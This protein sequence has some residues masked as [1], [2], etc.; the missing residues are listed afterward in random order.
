MK[1]MDKNE[2]IKSLK[3]KDL[4]QI[5]KQVSQIMLEGNYGTTSFTTYTF[6]G[7]Y[8][9]RLHNH[10][11]GKLNEKEVLHKFNNE[12]EFWNVPEKYAEIG[13]CNDK[14]ESM[15]YCANDIVTAILEVKPKAGDFVTVSNFKNLFP[16]KEFKIQPIAVRSLSKIT[17]LNKIL[18]RNYVFNDKHLNV[19][20][21]LDKL[22]CGKDEKNY[23]LSVAISHL[24]FTDTL[25]KSKT[26]ET[27]GLIYPS[28]IRN[29]TSYC[30]VL[31]PWVAHC[32]FE[33]S[34]IQT[35]EILEVNE[36]NLKVK[37][38]RNGQIM[39]HKIYPTDLFDI[40][41]MIPPNKTPKF[42][43]LYF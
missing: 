1:I 24:F 33:I 14:G 36:T 32:F 15:F 27:H 21:F 41:W 13:R 23:N 7:F 10:L 20:N 3:D 9:A 30:F 18:L 4:E 31:K 6:K 35:L 16:K 34:S 17:H 28:I 5:K 22:F 8:R 29:E 42:E 38:V 25:T 11:E 39:S 40:F 26:L 2:I 19:E 43:I 12:T 37:L